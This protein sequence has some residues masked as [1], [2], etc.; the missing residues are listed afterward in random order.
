[1]YNLSDFFLN[2]GQNANSALFDPT[3]PT[4]QKSLVPPTAMAASLGQD[5]SVTA[6][7]QS[8]A[9]PSGQSAAGAQMG[10]I[11]SGD[12]ALD[13][14]AGPRPQPIQGK[15]TNGQDLLDKYKGGS[16]GGGGLLKLLAA[17]M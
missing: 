15:N 6:T 12:Q 1:M 11:G 17:F 7:V 3:A 5:P 13:P 10:G 8:L 16:G 4:G 9:Q 2:Q 14:T